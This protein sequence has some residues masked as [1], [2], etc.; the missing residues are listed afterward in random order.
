MFGDWDLQL[1]TVFLTNK[2]V[3]APG[4]GND[5]SGF[6]KSKYTFTATDW[7]MSI[8]L[9]AAEVDHHEGAAAAGSFNL[10][11]LAHSPTSEY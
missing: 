10:Y 4:G 7:E 2:L 5:Q 1:S 8:D 3:L 9:E 11:F 6:L